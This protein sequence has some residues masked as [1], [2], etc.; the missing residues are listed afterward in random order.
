[1]LGLRLRDDLQLTLRWIGRDRL[2]H[3]MNV[4]AF[5]AIRH[6]PLDVDLTI[7]GDELAA[8]HQ[9]F[10]CRSVA[11]AVLVGGLPSGELRALDHV[12]L[13]MNTEWDFDDVAFLDHSSLGG[14]DFGAHR[15]CKK[16]DLRKSVSVV[17]RERERDDLGWRAR[18]DIGRRTT[19]DEHAC[20]HQKPTKN[21]THLARVHPSLANSIDTA[22]HRRNFAL[23]G[24]HDLPMRL[25]TYA[26]IAVLYAALAAAASKVTLTGTYFPDL[27]HSDAV[28]VPAHMLLYGGLA[29]G[30][31]RSG[32]S[33]RFAALFA[34][35]TGIFQELAQDLVFWRAPGMPELF[36]LV[37]DAT[38]VAIAL[39]V[40]PL[41]E[42]KTSPSA[43]NRRTMQL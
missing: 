10:E 23:I 40:G 20:E 2:E 27:I 37:V 31:W 24:E 18:R 25:W 14:F 15:K 6:R 4:V 1:M 12:Q 19:C 11:E 42:A 8:R 5:I 28:H 29:L 9:L 39:I 13:R 21:H 32:M 43:L 33:R 16:D 7:T 41:L 34:L 26:G 17:Y 38:A 35:G 30:A 22:R 36:D 3:L